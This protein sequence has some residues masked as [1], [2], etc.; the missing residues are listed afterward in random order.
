MASKALHRLVAA[1]LLLTGACARAPASP[2]FHEEG[3][4][5]TLSAW[6]LFNADGRSLALNRGVEPYDLATPLFTDYALKLRTISLPDG[7][8][9]RYDADGAFG[10]PV[11]KL[12]LCGLLIFQIHKVQNIRVS[13]VFT[14]Q[15]SE[16]LKRC[17]TLLQLFRFI[18]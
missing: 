4:P 1:V 14:N 16:D 11:K 10:F 12:F 15:A 17:F 3:Y 8:A 7:E 13:W 9:A 5:E 18:Y 2:V 6:G